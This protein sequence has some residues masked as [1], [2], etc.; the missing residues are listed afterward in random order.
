MCE[1]IYRETA[2]T[3]VRENREK[4]MRIA[5]ENLQENSPYICEGIQREMCEKHYTFPV[6]DITKIVREKREGCVEN[7]ERTQR[8]L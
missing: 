2:P 6:R 1:E 5:R 4:I 8:E 3:N 7:K